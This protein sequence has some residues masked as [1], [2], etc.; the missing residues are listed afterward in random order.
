MVVRVPDELIERDPAVLAPAAGLVDIADDQPGIARRRRGSGFSYQDASGNDIDLV[1]RERIEALAIPPA[2]NDV[3][4]SPDPLGYLQASGTDDAG[5]KQY[6][7]HDRFR[8][9]CEDR[10]FARLHYFARAVVVIRKATQRALDQP[11][12]SRDHAVAAAVA[13]IDRS[14]L[15]V[16]NDDSATN[17][18]YGATTL[19]VD[20]VVDDDVM[21]LNYTAK[22]GKERAVVIED[23]DLVAVLSELAED[24]DDELFWFDIEPDGERRRAT[25]SDVNHFIVEQ[26]GSAF[27]ARDF[28]TW[29][30]SAIAVE[31]RATGSR[32]LEAIDEAA[33]ELG[34]TRAVA[35]SSYVHPLI[36]EADDETIA[37]A[38]S[39]SRTSKWLGRSES[40]L[41]KLLMDAPRP[42]GW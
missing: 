38:W 4:I 6:R 1:E 32:V 39:S 35:R 10:K 11:L 24:A 17:G 25:A 29:G 33:D 22:S 12:G 40:A 23:E 2:W 31:A 42:S 9:F 37:E 27:S 34:N 5:R 14:L 28:R 41:A 8:S 30:G 3:W 15:R 26:V 19:T 7:Y 18:H 20:H 16:G 21:M 13:L 36:V